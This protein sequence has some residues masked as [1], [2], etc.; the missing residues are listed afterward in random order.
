M[1]SAPA[2]EG[3]GRRLGRESVDAGGISIA[4]FLGSVGAAAGYVASSA[5]DVAAATGAITFIVV[6]LVRL[7]LASAFGDRS[8]HP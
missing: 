2:G 1:P 3:W 6:Y 8:D 7:L 5:A 4:I